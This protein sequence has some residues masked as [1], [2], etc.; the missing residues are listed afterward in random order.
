[1]T[2][3]ESDQLDTLKGTLGEIEKKFKILSPSIKRKITIPVIFKKPDHENF[4]SDYLAYIL[5]PEINGIGIEPLQIIMKLTYGE[6]LDIE[7][8][9]VEIYR[10]YEFQNDPSCGRIDFLIEL[11]ENGENGVIGIEN[12]I[13]ADE[14]EGQT[15]VYERGIEED[16][17]GIDHYYIFLTRHGEKPSSAEFKKLS[18][19]Q[20]LKAFR[21][22]RYP[23]LENISKTVIW[24]D[25]LSHLEEYIIMDNRKLEI[26]GRAKLYLEHYQILEEMSDT[27]YK[28]SERVY[29][30]TVARIKEKLGETWR[31]NF[32]GQYNYQEINK[33]SWYFRKNFRIF[34]QYLFSKKNILSLEKFPYMLGVYP[35][36]KE[37]LHFY[38]WLKSNKPEIDIICKTKE[39]ETFQAEVRGTASYI[40]AIKKYPIV[41]EKE[42]LSNFQD[43]FILPL[44]EFN[45][46]TTIIDN[47]F[48]EYHK[49]I[50]D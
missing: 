18:Y 9:Q 19:K 4:I 11:G 2:N 6:I 46:L 12:K 22:I 27:F 50:N 48:L 37:S 30:F 1:M 45:Q 42:D 10:E 16:Y 21:D 13:Y 43:Q 15:K 5:D 8:D 23:T 29:D 17:K 34:T 7:L 3:L 47:A 14:S 20:L 36:N 24:E 41:I 26:S 39:I 40:I 32:K 49:L 33:E 44:D 38:E 28:D 35:K 25:F 31:T